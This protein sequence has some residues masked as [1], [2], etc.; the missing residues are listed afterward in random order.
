MCK[1]TKEFYS[2]ILR[3]C[4][5]KGMLVFAKSDLQYITGRLEGCNTPWGPSHYAARY[6]VGPF[7]KRR[8]VEREPPGSLLLTKADFWELASSWKERARF[9]L[10]RALNARS[11]LHRAPVSF[12]TKRETMKILSVSLLFASRRAL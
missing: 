12:D 1:V 4:L 7:A 2:S 8:P 10:D 6:F 11:E 9:E 5:L 3:S